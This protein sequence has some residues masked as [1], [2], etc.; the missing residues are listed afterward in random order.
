MAKG[1]GYKIGRD[2]D[3]GRYKSVEDAR[4]DPK[5]SSVEI[6]PKPGY[7]DTGRYDKPSKST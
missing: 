1:Q 4:R 5:N 2:D 3:T 6:N 7:G